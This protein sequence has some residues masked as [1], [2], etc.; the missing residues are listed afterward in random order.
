MVD[1][2]EQSIQYGSFG[3]YPILFKHKNKVVKIKANN[4][5]LLKYLSN[6]KV[7]SF[8]YSDEFELL[9]YSD[10]MIESETFSLSNL[11]ESLEKENLFETTKDIIL[12]KQVLGEFDD[13]L[14]AIFV[15]NSS[16][17]LQ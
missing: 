3:M 6:Y 7:S 17:Y 12:N 16:K 14:T 13:D 5:P 2:K 9:I 1:M 8:K 15:S 10:G 11:T 4:P